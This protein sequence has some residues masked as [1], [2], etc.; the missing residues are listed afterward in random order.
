[1]ARNTAF[2]LAQLLEKE[3]LHESGTNSVD[4][5]HNVRIVLKSANNDYVLEQTLGSAPADN[6]IDDAHNFF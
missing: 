5:F 1:M 3:K 2:P 6:A 4:S